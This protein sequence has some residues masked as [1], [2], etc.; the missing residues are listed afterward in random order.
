MTQ[1]DVIA[2]MDRRRGR[3][4]GA[5]VTEYAGLV[6]VAALLVGAL[7]A[8]GVP[9]RLAARTGETICRIFGYACPRHVAKPPPA[10]PPGDPDEPGKKNLAA[11]P[12]SCVVSQDVK[13]NTSEWKVVVVKHS[14]S[15]ATIVLRNR[16]GS[17]SVI[18][19]S[20]GGTGLDLRAG[21]GVEFGGVGVDA[22]LGASQ[23]LTNRT[24]GT[25]TFPSEKAHA[26]Y[27]KEVKQKQAE[28]MRRYAQAGALI[29]PGRTRLEEV[30]DE[31][32]K[33]WNHAHP[34]QPIRRSVMH[35]DGVDSNTG[36]ETT[37]GPAKAS[38]T[39]TH[40]IYQGTTVDDM[41][42]PDDRKDDQTTAYYEFS[43][44]DQAEAGTD[45]LGDK[46]SVGP[47]GRIYG[48]RESQ[49]RL[50]VVSQHGKPVQL[51]QSWR[52][53][54]VDGVKG[55]LKGKKG[56]SGSGKG[57]WSQGGVSTE[58][59]VVDLKKHPEVYKQWLGTY[60]GK[61]AG[62]SEDAYRRSLKAYGSTTRVDYARHTTSGGFDGSVT[63]GL[64]WAAGGN[65]KEHD[66]WDLNS[67]EYKKPG[68]D[69]WRP[70]V[71]CA[72]KG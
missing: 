42:T 69:T 44:S 31:V 66:R 52:R 32:Q 11:L 54:W 62:E 57:D 61:R 39:K 70:W 59:T 56:G 71:A 50:S 51:V 41:G 43:D 4:I 64:E 9:E 29:R 33:E 1:G 47:T 19:N 45:A 38:Y 16:N 48:K 14:H 58:E 25:T 63:A 72:K 7:V 10:H 40:G 34:D 6:V 35:A 12:N 21:D 24:L 2:E 46:I 18:G 67:A 5:T 20:E 3:D 37:F 68:E 65:K 26:W 36:L 23:L 53:P 27:D 22:T 49:L 8:A 60:L 13:T 55:S 15:T 17:V 30:R 28:L